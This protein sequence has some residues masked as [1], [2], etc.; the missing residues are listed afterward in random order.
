MIEHC[1]DEGLE[2]C[3]DGH[4]SM[5]AALATKLGFVDPA[6]HTAYELPPNAQPL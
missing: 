6:P 5:S 1:L 3:W 4:N 2:P